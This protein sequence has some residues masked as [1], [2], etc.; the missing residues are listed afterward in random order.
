MRDEI[1]LKI[2]HPWSPW[3]QTPF[4][5]KRETLICARTSLTV[6]A[7]LFLGTHIIA[8]ATDSLDQA[9]FFLVSIRA[10]ACTELGWFLFVLKFSV[11]LTFVAKRV[12]I[13]RVV[14]ESV[15]ITFAAIRGLLPET[16]SCHRHAHIKSILEQVAWL[17]AN[18][19]L[20]EKNFHLS[21]PRCIIICPLTRFIDAVDLAVAD[22]KV[23]TTLCFETQLRTFFHRAGFAANQ[24]RSVSIDMSCTSS[25]VCICLRHF[26]LWYVHFI[27]HSLRRELLVSSTVLGFF[28]TQNISPYEHN[29]VRLACVA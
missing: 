1:K 5:T 19:Y 12:K 27:Q 25:L 10:F 9:C 17:D 8:F 28:F 22:N 3:L 20:N 6:K 18:K 13:I 4:T 23:I 15:V 11:F 24:G 7:E 16:M 29:K 21:R 26:V 14:P 2:Q